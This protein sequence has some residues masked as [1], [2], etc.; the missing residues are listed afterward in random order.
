MTN[1][2]YKFIIFGYCVNKGWSSKRLNDNVQVANT[3]NPFT[4]WCKNVG[5]YEST[6]GKSGSKTSNLFLP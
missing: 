2:V 3:E 4:I 1:F 5:P 6:Y